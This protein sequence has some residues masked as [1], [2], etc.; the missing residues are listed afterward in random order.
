[1]KDFA[2]IDGG[3]LAHETRESRATVG[4][5]RQGSEGRARADFVT[6]QWGVLE[7]CLAMPS[8]WTAGSRDTATGLVSG[9]PCLSRAYVAASTAIQIVVLKVGSTA[10][11]IRYILCHVGRLV[12]V[13]A[14]VIA[15]RTWLTWAT[16][17]ERQDEELDEC[18]TFH[19]AQ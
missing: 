4:M 15:R 19:E 9:P 7:P 16:G 17:C 12:V 13:S 2:C 5:A 10:G 8:C 14:V 11:Q 6:R 3:R 1:M 18:E